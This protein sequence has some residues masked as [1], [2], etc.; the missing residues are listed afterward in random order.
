MAEDHPHLKAL[1]SVAKASA[2]HRHQ[3][4]M[5]VRDGLESLFRCERCDARGYADAS[6]DPPYLG[7]SLF[8]DDCP[9]DTPPKPTAL[10]MFAPA[11]N[12]GE[13]EPQR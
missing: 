6:S 2:S 13:A 7:G 12:Y 9:Y 3:P 4:A 5:V 8:E 1:E 11:N 10:W